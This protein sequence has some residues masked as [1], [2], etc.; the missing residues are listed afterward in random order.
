MKVSKIEIPIKKLIWIRLLKISTGLSTIK[1]NMED[2]EIMKHRS[3]L[4]KSNHMPGH[5]VRE[6]QHFQ[7]QRYPCHPC[8]AGFHSKDTDAI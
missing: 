1:N 6:K 3:V 7:R 2:L 5:I 8:Q 4:G